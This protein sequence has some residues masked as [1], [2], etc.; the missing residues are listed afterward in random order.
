[1]N[2][3]KINKIDLTIT[4]A[5]RFILKAMAWKKRIQKDR[6]YLVSASKEG[7]AAKRASLDLTRFLA[8]FRKR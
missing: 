1:V 3:E 6:F 4:E 7:G 8:E 5:R 2:Q